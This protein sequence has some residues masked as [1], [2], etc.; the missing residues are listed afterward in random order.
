M[1]S[2]FY[3]LMTLPLA[4]RD[5]H[6]VSNP[7]GIETVHFF[8]GEAQGRTSGWPADRYRSPRGS[9]IGPIYLDE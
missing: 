8:V 2:R 4:E 1:G 9:I 6:G 3:P 7:T 5:S